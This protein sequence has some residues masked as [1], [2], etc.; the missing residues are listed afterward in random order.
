M[1][2]RGPFQPRPVPLC[3]RCPQPTL[4]ASLQQAQ[5]R[6]QCLG[7]WGAQPEHPSAKPHEE[8][9]YGKAVPFQPY[10]HQHSPGFS[11]QTHI[12]CPFSPGTPPRALPMGA[13]IPP[14]PGCI[15]APLCL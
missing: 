14:K 2:H 10:L 13:L 9:L 1:T 8:P 15:K 4:Q 5:H 3:S 12:P 7:K 6:A 11:I